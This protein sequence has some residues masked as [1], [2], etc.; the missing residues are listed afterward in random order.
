MDHKS[1][2]GAVTVEAT[3]C[4]VLVMFVFLFFISFGFLLYQR[5][6]VHIVANE[7]AEEISQTYKYTDAADSSLIT[8]DHVDHVPIF[9][10]PFKNGSLERKNEEKLNN[11]A[12]ARMMKTSLAQEEGALKVTVERIPDDLGRYHLEITVEQRYGFLL[13][14]LLDFVGVS[15]E[16]TLK[17]TVY[18]AGTDV[19]YY[20]NSIRTTDNLADLI[21]EDKLAGTLESAISIVSG[22][23]GLFS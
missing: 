2:R 5:C 8:G 20:V 7:M 9:R 11:L 6:L 13:G 4:V 22:I 14:D 3:W 15:E 23:A 1:E 17:S 10:F 21:G 16:E 19:L 18:V 12:N